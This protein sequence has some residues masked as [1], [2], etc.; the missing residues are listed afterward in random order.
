MVPFAIQKILS[1]IRSHCFFFFIFI[2]IRKVKHPLMCFLVIYVSSWGDVYLDLLTIFGLFVVVV[3][4][5]SCMSYLDILEINPLFAISFA[6]IFSHSVNCLFGFLLVSFAV[7]KPASLMR[8]HWFIFAF[9]SV[10]LGD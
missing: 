3:F 8:S 2:F 9:I 4:I 7:Q 10:A 6:N 5:L 1:V